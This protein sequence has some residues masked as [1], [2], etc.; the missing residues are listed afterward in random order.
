MRSNSIRRD[1]P[2]SVER[3]QDEDES[4]DQGQFEALIVGEGGESARIPAEEL[5]GGGC[6][7]TKVEVDGLPRE[8]DPVADA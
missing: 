5:N 7:T 1:I 3:S 2:C 6:G 8:L 4:E